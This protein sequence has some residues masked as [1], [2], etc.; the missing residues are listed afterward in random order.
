MIQKGTMLNVIDNSGAKKSC[1]IQVLKG[2]RKRYAKVGDII[3][4]SIKSLR[5]QRRSTTKIKKGDV[6]KALVIR[7]KSSFQSYNFESLKFSENEVVLLNR[8]NKLLATRIL[9]VVPQ[10]FRYSRFLRVISL[11]SNF[12]K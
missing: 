4:V 7:T 9:G 1:C 3:V 6:T 2:Y 10:T 12:V 5:L 8:Q 11:A